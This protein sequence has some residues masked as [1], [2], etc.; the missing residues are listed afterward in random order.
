[1][2]QI[3]NDKYQ[4]IY[5]MLYDESASENINFLE[6]WQKFAFE[7]EKYLISTNDEKW[8]ECPFEVL[9]AMYSDA[10]SGCSAGISY[11]PI[12]GYF[13]IYTC[14]QGPGI[15]LYEHFNE[16]KFLER[17]NLLT[18]EEKEKFLNE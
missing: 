3:L 14:G 15:G 7:L 9:D 10:E 1:M 16:E 12:F 4:Y 13:H 5:K 17:V 2:I 11:H 6:N 8:D 18:K